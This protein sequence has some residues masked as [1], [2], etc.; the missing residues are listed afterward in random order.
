[1]FEAKPYPDVVRELLFDAV[2]GPRPYDYY[3]A[4]EALADELQLDKAELQWLRQKLAVFRDQTGTRK[5]LRLVLVSARGIV[6]MRPRVGN[7]FER[8]AA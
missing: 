3:V 5:A 7:H 4:M 8:V 1:M 2:Q 6:D